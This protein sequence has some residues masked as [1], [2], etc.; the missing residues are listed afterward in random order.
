MAK[1]TKDEIV[2]VI[3]KVTL[4]KSLLNLQEQNQ[5]GYTNVKKKFIQFKKV[6]SKESCY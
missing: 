1:I 4:L 2:E 6:F 3:K 5:R